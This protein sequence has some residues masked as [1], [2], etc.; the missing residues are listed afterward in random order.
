MH[1]DDAHSLRSV[2]QLKPLTPTAQTHLYSPNATLGPVLESDE[3]H[4]APFMHG[5][6]A[7]SFTSKA[8]VEPLKP[9]GHWHENTS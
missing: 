5:E 1:G 7:H 4:V 3:I 6:D 2:A 8:Q 9:T